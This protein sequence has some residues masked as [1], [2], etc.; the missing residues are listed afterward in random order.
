[1]PRANNV[2]PS[3]LIDATTGNAYPYP[4]ATTAP[5]PSTRPPSPFLDDMNTVGGLYDVGRLTT[6]N[7]IIASYSSGN[8]STPFQFRVE[9]PPT[10][11]PRVGFW[12]F[13]TATE[14]I[15]PTFGDRLIP[16]YSAN[17]QTI[18]ALVASPNLV[19]HSEDRPYP[20]LPWDSITNHKPDHI[21]LVHE[22]YMVRRI[23]SYITDINNVADE[24]S[25]WDVVFIIG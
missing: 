9:P 21:G 8:W 25:F 19:S 1:M 6:L 16:D 7:R 23:I 11:P 22:P 15:K 4:V 5:P 12:A 17:L 20:A 2:T 18:P 3:Y 14:T 13:G 24:E 10:S